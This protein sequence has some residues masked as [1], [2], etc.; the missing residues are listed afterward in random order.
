MAQ[1][2]QMHS[3]TRKRNKQKKKKK[4]PQIFQT[5]QTMQ[6]KLK[7]HRFEGNHCNDYTKNIQHR[8]YIFNV[9]LQIV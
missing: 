8:M 9:K 4:N 7:L 3:F 6:T 2:W 1:E 5:M